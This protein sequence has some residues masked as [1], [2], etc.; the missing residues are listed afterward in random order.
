MRR[1]LLPFA[2]VVALV[3]IAIPT[4]T[5]VGC[6]T[7]MMGAMAMPSTGGQT[8]SSACTGQWELST[9]PAGIVPT[10]TSSLLLG[11]AVALV[12]AVVLL[13]PQRS[14]RFALT[15]V[16]DPPPPPHDPLGERF[17]V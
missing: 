8:I 9:S 10:G 6:D 3:A 16:G 13:A 2:I 4:Y 11:F 14:A 7:G 5:M 12:A 15:F 17:R 1:L